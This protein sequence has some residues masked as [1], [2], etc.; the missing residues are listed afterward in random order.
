VVAAARARSGEPHPIMPRL[1][2]GAL[3]LPWDPDYTVTGTGEGTP[4]TYKPSWAIGP[5]RFVMDG[6]AWKH[7]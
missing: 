3:L 5:S 2:A 6:S 7:V 4:L 1:G